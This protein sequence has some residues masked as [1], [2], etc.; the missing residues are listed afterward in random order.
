MSKA[1]K[2]NDNIG[3]K[4]AY[5]SSIRTRNGDLYKRPAPK[6]QGKKK[7]PTGEKKGRKPKQ[8]VVLELLDETE[9]P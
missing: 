6:G 1:L 9:F 3:D 8:P 4:S 2:I 5:Y 7:V